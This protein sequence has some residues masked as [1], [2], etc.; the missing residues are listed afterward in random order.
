MKKYFFLNNQ[1]KKGPYSL[2]DILFSVNSEALKENIKK[3]T[4]I[5]HEGLDDWVPIHD[6]TEFHDLLSL[7]PPPIPKQDSTFVTT[8]SE[9]EQENVTRTD[10]DINHKVDSSEAVN[11][12][13]M[14]SSVFSMT[15]RIR[16]LEYGLSYVFF[17]V[18]SVIIDVMVAS[19]MTI[20]VLLYIPITWIIITQGAKR[21]HDIGNSGWYQLIPF[22]F[23]WMIFSD[24][25]KLMN[26]YGHPPKIH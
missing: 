9:N 21:C 6:V 18:I 19:G 4:L 12:Q 15:G 17:T 1:E 2:D 26:K 24:G 8:Y 25:N 20:W 10:K 3:D 5:W 13:D 11:K 14:F 23:L 16:R 7:N 22:Y